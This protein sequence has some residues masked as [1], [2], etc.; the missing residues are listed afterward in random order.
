MNPTAEYDD[1]L[2][3]VRT[4]ERE[5]GDLALLRRAA[6]MAKARNTT[7]GVAL[8]ALFNQTAWMGGRDLALLS[9]IP[10]DEI[11]AL[12]TVVMDGA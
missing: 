2:H 9:R 1:I 7:E 12:A 8:E 6:D 4:D 3:D 5:P 10:C 11:L